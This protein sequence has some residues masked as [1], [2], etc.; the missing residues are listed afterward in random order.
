MVE[1]DS[2]TSQG[3]ATPDEHGAAQP[4]PKKCDAQAHGDRAPSYLLWEY[5]KSRNAIFFEGAPGG[6][7]W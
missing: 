6:S 5:V 2:L 3:S 4:G 1:A 7:G